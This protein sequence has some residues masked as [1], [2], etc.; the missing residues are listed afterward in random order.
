MCFLLLAGHLLRDRLLIGPDGRWRSELEHL[1]G[2]LPAAGGAPSASGAKPVLN[3]PLSINTAPLD[4]LVLLPGV[5][6]VLAG[7][8]LAA[9]REGLVFGGPDDLVRIKGIGPR[10]AGKLDTLLAY[11]CPSA[12]GAQDLGSP[13]GP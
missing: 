4:S 9:R 8:I 1:P 2:Q 6:P 10:L 3:I 5:G 13:A 7:R 12:Q 11:A